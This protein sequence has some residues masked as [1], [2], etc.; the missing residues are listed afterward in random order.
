VG[1]K[2]EIHVR[3]ASASEIAKSIF[4]TADELRADLLV[5]A[6]HGRSGLSHVFLGSVAEAVVR[7]ARCPVLTVRP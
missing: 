1:V 4:E 6:T 3:F 7:N 2:H 5:M